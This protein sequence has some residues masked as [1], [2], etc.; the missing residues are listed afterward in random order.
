MS[1]TP[2]N[3]PRQGLGDWHGDRATDELRFR[4]IKCTEA[5]QA[6]QHI[7]QMAAE[8][9]AIGVQFV[10]HHVLQVLEELHPFCVMGQDAGMQHVRIGN[11]H[12][13]LSPYR[14]SRIL[15]RVA[16]VGEGLDILA[17]QLY[18]LIEL[19]HLVLCQSLGRK[20]IQ[21]SSVRISKMVNTG[22]L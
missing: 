3:E 5:L 17:T 16:I 21:S 13:P 8:N 20:E 1:S 14:P 6:A 19:F 4:T 7:G 9:T 22:M 18:E 2:F 15:R 11:D 12:V 10:N